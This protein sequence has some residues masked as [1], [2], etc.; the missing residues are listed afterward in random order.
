MILAWLVAPITNETT[1]RI[2]IWNISLLFFYVDVLCH[3]SCRN[4]NERKHTT[5]NIKSKW[6]MKF[7]FSLFSTFKLKYQGIS[8]NIN[9][10]TNT[11]APPFLWQSKLFMLSL[12]SLFFA[13]KILIISKPVKSFFLS[14]VM[15]HLKQRENNAKFAN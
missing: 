9:S 6:L 7:I 13:N 5:N 12:L 11:N 14:F 2:M 10:D 4:K 3:K 15:R 8:R 1:L